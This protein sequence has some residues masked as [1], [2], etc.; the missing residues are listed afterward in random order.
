VGPGPPRVGA[1]T[2]LAATVLAATVLVSTVLASTDQ[3]GTST[4]RAG[5]STD[6]RRR[7]QESWTT[8]A[9]R[10]DLPPS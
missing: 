5:T 10:C 6:P 1:R 2:V 4:D 3:A 8:P 7:Q 9:D